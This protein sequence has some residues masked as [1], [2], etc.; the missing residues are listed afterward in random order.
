VVAEARRDQPELHR[1]RDLAAHF[2]EGED[3]FAT[4]FIIH[5]KTWRERTA[6]H[7]EHMQ[8]G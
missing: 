2:R 1:I 7:D 4:G 5:E 3:V 8:A 6:C